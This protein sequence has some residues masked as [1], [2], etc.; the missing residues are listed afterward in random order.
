MPLRSRGN[1]SRRVGSASPR[2]R[3][4]RVTGSVLLSDGKNQ[5]ITLAA[6]LDQAMACRGT[7]R[8]KIGDRSRVGG[9]N[10]QNVT[11]RHLFHHS[12]GA[13]DRQRATQP[14][15]IQTSALGHH[16]SFARCDPRH[17][18]RPCH[19]SRGGPGGL[20]PTSWRSQ[21]Q[22]G[23]AP[24]PL[25]GRRRAPPLSRPDS[26]GPLTSSHSNFTR[27]LAQPSDD[28]GILVRHVV[29]RLRPRLIPLTCRKVRPRHPTGRHAEE[30]RIN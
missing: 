3:A 11:N 9:L 8:R 29:A 10:H 14:F 25:A 24:A 15:G 1:K 5:D 20:N 23:R 2:R 28:R 16:S 4:L 26:K 27:S 18:D 19:R 17:H 12:A 6:T 13:Q 22:R 21:P 7:E 30:R